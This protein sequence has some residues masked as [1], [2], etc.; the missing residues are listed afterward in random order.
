MVP[1]HPF[2]LRLSVAAVAM[3]LLSLACY[4][5]LGWAVW[6]DQIW[7]SALVGEDR[8]NRLHT[9]Y[10]NVM[11]TLLP[12]DQD[13]DGVCDGAELF[14]HTSPRNPRQHS[15]IGFHW[16]RG[17]FIVYDTAALSIGGPMD[18]FV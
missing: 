2:L 4:V 6:T 15:P 9:T 12:G 3:L 11:A 17:G 7:L 1:R 10:G 14:L 16:E 13:R 5:G 8:F 18:S